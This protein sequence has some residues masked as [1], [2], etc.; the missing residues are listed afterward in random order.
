MLIILNN[1]SNLDSKE[2]DDYYES[3]KNVVSKH[4]LILCPSSI[5]LTRVNGDNLLLGSQNVSSFDNGSYT[6]EVSARQLKSLGV[7]YAIVGHSE[8]RNYQNEDN[9][10]IHQ[11]IKELLNQNITPILCV[12]ETK[13]EKENYQTIDKI[14]K[15]L[16]DSL[17]SL[18]N[19]DNV[20]IA[21]EPIWA[22]G[23]GNTL[24][25]EEIED[26]L[27]KIKEKY[28]NNKL[29]YGGSVNEKN[30]EELKDSKIIDGFLLGGLS[31]KIDKLKLFL[32]KIEEV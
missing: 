9:I 11:K 27:L 26:I 2:F 24:T 19:K 30:I 5:Y 32:E 7:E 13:E 31:L 17:L 20:V 14:Y 29:V 4:P 12:G 15:E 8:R 18:P 21:Y 10:T 28:P 25:R 3:L 1:K 22:I 23:T 16:E 6:G